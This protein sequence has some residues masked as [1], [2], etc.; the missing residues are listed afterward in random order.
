ME[1]VSQYVVWSLKHT[2]ARW[3]WTAEFLTAAVGWLVC[4]TASH[5]PIVACRTSIWVWERISTREVC[6]QGIAVIYVPGASTFFANLYSSDDFSFICVR[7]FRRCSRCNPRYLTSVCIG[8]RTLFIVT[9]GQSVGLV[10]NV[11]WTDFVLLILILHLSNHAWR[12]LLH[13]EG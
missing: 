3:I 6:F 8:I 12:S 2:A 4:G 11:T 7:Q 5:S 1:L 9:G 13:L 10:F